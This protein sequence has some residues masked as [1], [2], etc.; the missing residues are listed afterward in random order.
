VSVWICLIKPYL[1]LMQLAQS[2][3]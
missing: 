1:L 2:K 3:T